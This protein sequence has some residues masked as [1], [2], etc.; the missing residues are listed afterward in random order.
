MST[1]FDQEPY[2][3]TW[4]SD[5]GALYRLPLKIEGDDARSLSFFP[6][7]LLFHII[8]IESA[9]GDMTPPSLSLE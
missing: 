5:G 3:Y 6:P 8:S 7:L 1:F 4:Y 2:F 9:L